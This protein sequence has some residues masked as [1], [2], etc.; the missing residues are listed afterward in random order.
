MASVSVGL[1][2]FLDVPMSLF[3]VI[4]WFVNTALAYISCK[5][6][7]LS[8]IRLCNIRNC[9]HVVTDVTC[10]LLKRIVHFNNSLL[11][12]LLICLLLSHPLIY[13][14][15]SSFHHHVNYNYYSIIVYCAIHLP[16]L[17]YH[18]NYHLLFLT[19]FSSQPSII[20]L[21]L[22]HLHSRSQ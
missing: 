4:V 3:I 10:L 14:F 2:T 13:P 6:T 22:Q 20:R 18:Y 7:Y 19:H 15:I 9:S 1:G 17:Y 11:L 5:N 21:L 8:D 16:Y 12:L